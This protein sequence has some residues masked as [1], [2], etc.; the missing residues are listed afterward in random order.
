M[1]V[2]ASKKGEIYTL[3]HV[4]NDSQIGIHK[5]SMIYGGVEIA[6]TSFEILK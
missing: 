6:T 5:I 2:F 1:E 3:L 4:T